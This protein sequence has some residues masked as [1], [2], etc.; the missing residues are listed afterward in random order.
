MHPMIN[1]TLCA[2][3]LGAALSAT[4]DDRDAAF[5]K[6]Y[7]LEHARA[8]Y[9]AAERLYADV[10][11]NPAHSDDA[12]S[13]AHA[14][15]A[16]VREERRSQNLLALLP[17]RSLAFV[18]I[19][20]PG[21][22]LTRFLRMTGLLRDDGH[23]VDPEQKIGISAALVRGLLDVR[24]AAVAVTG[25][26]FENGE[27]T[28]VAVIHPGSVETIRGLIETA[29]PAAAQPAGSENGYPLWNIEGEAFVALT[30]R[31]AI[32]G[33]TRSDVVG[34]IER[35]SG[36]GGDSLIDN[37]A[38]TDALRDSEGSLIRFCVNF[39][40]I[41]PMLEMAAIG[42]AGESEEA[43]LAQALLDIRSLRTV[44]GGIDVADDGLTL[45]MQVQ[46]ASDHRN[47][48]FNALRLPPIEGRTLERIPA[49]AAAFAMMALN[50]FDPDAVS[51]VTREADAISFM[52]IGREVFG[53]MASVAIFVMPD[54]PER[55]GGAQIPAVAAV[56]TT[57]EAGK[58]A[59]LWGQLLGI[60]SVVTESGAL[61]GTR[62]KVDGQSVRRYDL[63][64][65]VALYVAEAE[66]DLV[67]TPHRAALR[68]ALS[69]LSPDGR[70][71]RND[72]AFNS[73]VAQIE[74]AAV[75]A[76][77]A[78]LGRCVAIAEHYADPEDIAEALPIP[79]M[80]DRT[81]LSGVYQHADDRARFMLH[82][83]GLPDLGEIA[84]FMIEKEMHSSRSLAFQPH[85]PTVVVQSLREA[86]RR[87][88]E[89]AAFKWRK[90]R[91]I[92]QSESNADRAQQ[93]A[94]QIVALENDANQLND[95]AWELATTRAIT[96]SGAVAAQILS[97]RS[98]ELTDYNNWMY[99]DTLAHAYFAINDVRAAVSWQRKAVQLAGDQP[100]AEEARRA[101][102]RFE[103]RL[104]EIEQ[105]P[106]Q[107]AA[108]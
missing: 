6:A 93:L 3:V 78:H 33:R 70:S 53:N 88:P 12:R 61:D 14:R 99:V 79:G 4:A 103:R 86:Q 101:L 39:A 56:V 30:H 75:L 1:T 66:H 17:S 67:I 71:I 108:S 2:L 46:L 50:A 90:L 10:V 9:A 96:Q 72:H 44:T 16:I 64:D 105:A 83:A 55:A 22:E 41:A 80:L 31:L 74:D 59:A 47:L 69:T 57:N 43:R 38:L 45:Q 32:A 98:N 20:E 49:G 102:Q 15:L 58:S 37:P 7:Y 89:N 84:Q 106:A 19:D 54:R 28:G 24:G 104:A 21:A 13:E 85:D 76:V 63:P 51:A 35:L 97:K 100:R 11:K 26:D 68:A 62:I 91:A 94:R 8:D 40:D 23:L 60:A 36:M 92:A 95:W 29:L 107:R 27:P 65:G 73:V 82:L 77:H 52:D 48:I 87:H 34:V 18:Q 5:Y 81:S 25:F 42:A